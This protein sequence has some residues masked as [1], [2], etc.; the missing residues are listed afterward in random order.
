MKEPKLRHS[1]PINESNEKDFSKIYEE[2]EDNCEV[3]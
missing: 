2:S 1:I 3:I